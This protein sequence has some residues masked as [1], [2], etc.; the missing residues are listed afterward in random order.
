MEQDALKPHVVGE[1]EKTNWAQ[2]D[3]DILVLYKTNGHC[4]LH[5]VGTAAMGPNETDV[6]DSQLR[7][8][9]VQGL[10]VVDCS[11]FREMPSGNTNA[12]VMAAAWRL[13][14]M[15]REDA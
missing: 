1:T 4:G 2:S 6:L 13:S 7:V 9:G 14:Q 5:A 15:M 11:I 8:R 3:E 12:P 10:L